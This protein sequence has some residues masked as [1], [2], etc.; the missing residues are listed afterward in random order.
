MSN[1]LAVAAV[2]ATL[3]HNLQAVLDAEVSS[4]TAR[5]ATLRPNA[6][7]SDLP[8]PGINIFLFQVTP[9]AALRNAD[10]P[11]RR[12]DGSLLNRP[13]AAL[14]LHYLLSFYGEDARLEPQILLGC[15]ARALHAQPV[16]TRDAIQATLSLPMFDFVADSD[17]A[18]AIDLVRFTQT[19]LSLEEMSKLWSVFLQ[20][21]YVLSMAYQASVVLLDR[22]LPVAAPL[23]V[24]LPPNIYTVQTRLPVIAQVLSQ[25]A[26]LAPISANQ[27]ILPGY[28][29]VLAGTQLQG[30][31]TVVRIDGVDTPATVTDEQITIPLP[32]TLRAGTHGVQVVHEL[33]MGTPPVPHTVLPSN[34]A[35]FALH[36]TVTA[37][38]TASAVTLTVAPRVG[39]RQ[40]VRLLLSPL[41]GSGGASYSFEAPSRDVPAAPDDTATVTVPISGVTAGTYLVRVEVDGAQSPLGFDAGTGA[42]NS[43]TVAIP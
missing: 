19:A 25:S 21:P 29:L 10:L 26:P 39:K 16:L 18:S 3:R 15:A 6:P 40:R 4:F 22:E 43:P 8:A 28:L 31:T 27:P 11:T 9:N 1:H 5:V 30:P 37:T 14:D 32:A 36:P 2:T 17:L 7:A 23:P 20:S 34:L 38:A 33:A 35:A 42:Y 24:R 13:A 12:G 41:P